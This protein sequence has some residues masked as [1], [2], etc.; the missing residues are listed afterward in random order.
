MLEAGFLILLAVVVGLADLE[1]ALIV[2]VMAIAWL[3]VALIEYFAWRQSSAFS[4]AMRYETVAEPA[5]PADAVRDEVI[6]E[7]AAPT[8]PSAT[9][10][11]TVIEPAAEPAAEPAEPGVSRSDEE[12]QAPDNLEPSQPRSRRRWILFGRRKEPEGSVEGSSEEEH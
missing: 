10:E 6:V 11:E 7:K 8:A 2:L 4:T 5:P 12:E 1:P 9:D 3:L